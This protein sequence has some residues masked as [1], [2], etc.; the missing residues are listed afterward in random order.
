MNPAYQPTAR[1]FSPTKGVLHPFR[2]NLSGASA[3]PVAE[4]IRQRLGQKDYPCIAAL[5]SYHKDEYQVG[6]YGRFGS[7]ESWRD[8]RNDLLFFLS[9][10]RRSSSI[11]LTFW[12]VFEPNEMGEEEFE[13]RLWR[14]LSCLTSEEEKHLDWKP[15]AS[16][17]PDDKGFRFSLGGTEFFVV[18]LHS[19]NSRLA[20]RFSRPCL[21]FNVFD[22]FEQLAKLGQY[23]SMVR[24]NRERDV[25]FQGDV[26]PMVAE[27]GE[28]WETIQFSGRMNE[29]KWKCPFHFLWA[30]DKP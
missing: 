18:G 14:E 29:K 21:V 16:T 1:L 22:Q 6:L 25:K 10:Q 9:E 20:R 12:A 3:R 28:E 30:K 15:G 13:E 2:G 8:L 7:G 17:D 27:H 26:N 23:D 24:I 19:N 11:Y 5:R 4:E